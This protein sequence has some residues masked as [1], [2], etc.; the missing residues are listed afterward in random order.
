MTRGYDWD[1]IRANYPLQEVIGRAI[2][3]RKVSGWY[4]AMC[5]FHDEKTASLKFR[6][7]DEHWH[8]FGCS[9]HG[10]VI[11]FVSKF[12]HVSK[13]EAIARLTGGKAIEFSEEDRRRR[14]AWIKAEEEKNAARR[15]AAIELARR[16]WDRA[17]SVEGINGYL[18]RKQIAPYMARMEGENLLVPMWDQDGELINVQAIPPEDGAD[19]LFHTGC[20]TV[21]AR[22]YIGGPFSSRIIVCEGFATGASVY[23]ATADHVCVAFSQGQVGN[24]VREL[25][26]AGRDVVIAADRKA[27]DAMVRL[28]AEL[29]IPV[30]APPVLAKGDDFNDQQVEQGIEAVATTFRQGLLE[31]ANRPPPPPAAP[32]CSIAFVDAMDFTENKIPLRPWIIPGALLA[33]STHILAAP[34]GTGKSVFTLQMALM[35]ASGRPWAKWQP[36]KKCRV[37][38]INAEDDID[39]QR[40]RMVAARSV[41]GFGAD[42]GMIMLADAPE[43]ILM[44]T[45]DPVKKSLIATPLVG[46]LV[47]IIRHHKIDVVIVDP[48][49]ETFDGDENSN[50][51]TKWAMKIWRDQIARP[52]GCAVYLV[53]HTTKGSEDKAGSADVIRGGGAIVNSARLAATLFVMTKGEA[54]PLFVKEDDRFRYVRYDDAKSNNSLVGG[55]T[56]FEKVSVRLQN[57]PAGDSEGGDEVGALRPWVPNGVGAYEPAQIVRLL[58]AVDDGYVDEHGVATEQP[59]S[60]SAAGGSRRWIGHLIGDMMGVEEDEARNII[61]IL[62]DG[63][64]VEEYEYHDNLKGRTAKGLRSNMGAANKALGLSPNS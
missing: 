20:P 17:P 54:G 63:G 61:K 35:L 11:D 1:A 58:G 22:F 14:D 5:P 8:C 45:P 15:I 26:E 62:I 42:R 36:K 28:G 50:G 48:F 44:S 46:Q 7:N 57:G 53:H 43:N 55:R 59:F 33:G 51:D 30:I 18:E 49:A 13:P 37:L 41:M 47:D 27:L 21:G 19:K 6:E 23:E 24:I 12:E 56:W 16:R 64:L 39:E 31:F 3:V 40:R 25:M 60:R 10:D 4:E 34:G 29:D 32:E 2:K 38:I 52:T 9:A